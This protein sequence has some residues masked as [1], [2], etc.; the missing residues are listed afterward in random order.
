MYIKSQSLYLVF[1]DNEDRLKNIAKTC[2][3]DCRKNGLLA[4]EI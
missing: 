2:A 4:I 1:D 3:T